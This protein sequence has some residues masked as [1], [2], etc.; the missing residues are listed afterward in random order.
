MIKSLHIKKDDQVIVLS[1]KDKGKIGKVIKVIPKKEKILLEK[2]NIV[3]RHTRPG[4]NVKGGILEKESPLHVSKLM[5]ICSKCNKPTRV[6]RK[7]L[8]S[9]EKVRICRKCKEIIEG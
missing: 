8:E 5:I 9:G 2:V 7:F 1:G 4:A 6:K 3:K